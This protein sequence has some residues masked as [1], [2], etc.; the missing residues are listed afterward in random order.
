MRTS[1][2]AAKNEKQMKQRAGDGK[3]APKTKRK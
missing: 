2:R 1:E 3:R